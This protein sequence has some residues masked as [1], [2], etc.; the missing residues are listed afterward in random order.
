MALPTAPANPVAAE[1]G[2]PAGCE[3]AGAG[4]APRLTRDTAALP[5]PA[6]SPPLTR[7]DALRC[8]LLA[9]SHG[10]SETEVLRL[11]VQQAVAAI[12]GFAGLV[13]VQGNEAHT[14]RL[15]A[16]TGLPTE[17]ARA[18][19]LLECGGDTAYDNALARGE[20]AWSPVLPVCVTGGD[21][22]GLPGWAGV[23]MVAAPVLVDGYPVGVLSVLADERPV[24][25]RL[26]F[27]V[28]LAALLG[29]R[30]RNARRWATG[31]APWWQEPVAERTEVMQQIAVGRWSW[32][33]A[34]G[35]LDID[36]AKDAILRAAG[37]PPEKWDGRIET[38][39]SRIHPDDRPGVQ[40]A[41]EFSL[42]SRQQYV[43]QYRVFDDDSRVSWLELRGTFEYDESGR[44]T[45]MHGTAWDVT[46]QRGKLDW[47]VGFLESHPDPIH[48]VATDNRVKWANKAAHELAAADDV[49][50][51]GAVLWD[52]VPRLRGQGL[53]ELFARARAAPG[54]AAT[55]E[56][57][58]EAPGN[59]CGAHSFHLVRA[60]AVE[61]FV[62]VQMSDITD[63]RR[64]ERAA[65]ERVRRVAELNAALVGALATDDVVAVVREHLPPLFGAQR[66]LLH[67]L[68][69]PQPRLLGQAGHPAEF[70]EGMRD[71]PCAVPEFVQVAEARFVTSVEVSARGV[72]ELLSL[73]RLGGMRSWAALPLTSASGRPIGSCVLGWAASGGFTPDDPPLLTTLATLIAQALEN[74]RLYEEARNRAER[75]QRE[76]L[77]SGLPDL[78]AVQTAARYRTAKGQEVGGDWYDVVP[79]PGGRVL[80]VIG[81]VMGHGFEQAITMGIIRHAVLAVAALDLPVDELMA[82]LNDV[83]GRLGQN[84]NGSA[85]YAT[86]LF[87]VYDATSGVCAVAS[88][89]HPAPIAVPPAA[90]PRLLDVTAGA[91]LGLA[92]VPAEVTEFTL[93]ANS[94]LVFYTNGL[95]GSAAPD[96]TRLTDAI[97]RHAGEASV[98]VR[99]SERRAWLEGL[100]DVVTAELP[101]D[102]RHDDAALLVLGID[103]VATDHVAQWDLPWAAESASRGRDLTSAQLAAWSLTDLSDATTLIVSELIG[104][105]VRH[106]VGLGA[107]VADDGDGV[108][109][110]RLLHLNEALICEVYDGSEAT[111]R[112]RHPSFDDE[113]GRGLQLVAIMTEQWGARYAE[114]GKCIWALLKTPRA[115]EAPV[116]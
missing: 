20:A 102:T 65:A 101:S 30:L 54:S 18:W 55:S 106:A 86:C 79:L 2:S 31:T 82:H 34:T 51:D 99:K 88:A 29:Q 90:E 66:L 81:D 24:P 44:A 42:S 1:D 8:G 78:P 73:A 115:G 6:V 4:P 63:K 3:T 96:T 80:T 52:A 22:D 40:K 14:L 107:D 5:P 110:L 98:P 43:V 83:V 48:V 100:C 13:H 87:A 67:D 61:D 26:D 11:A 7:A 69:G 91:P 25:G 33:I 105:T 56:L 68:T 77:P 71:I 95:L 39:M 72:P 109:R 12:G 16:V 38:W 35:V 57:E 70:L 37:L 76:L 113:F 17:I 46:P 9:D 116:G 84:A 47:L 97:S 53:S 59:P 93:D 114:D 85:V 60:V 64:T 89:G 94:V 28:R 50:V 21:G 112:V 41:I 74:A 104:N 45:R 49:E 111:P 15:A 58:A 19:E 62:A 108:I 23:G 75:L 10:L 27:L 36:G 92:Q 32:D 103:R